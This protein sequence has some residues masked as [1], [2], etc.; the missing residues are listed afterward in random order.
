VQKTL[1]RQRKLAELNRSESSS[2]AKSLTKNCPQ[3]IRELLERGYFYH[4]EPNWVRVP[5]GREYGFPCSP[6]ALEK[7]SQLDWRGQEIFAGYGL[8]QN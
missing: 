1:D 5:A 4:Y 8:P 7:L 6:I 3:K 2:D